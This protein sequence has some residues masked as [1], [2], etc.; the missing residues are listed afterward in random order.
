M[1]ALKQDKQK[2]KELRVR[3]REQFPN[4]RDTHYALSVLSKHT[5]QTCLPQS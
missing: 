1:N 3:N 2:P 4:H 5:L